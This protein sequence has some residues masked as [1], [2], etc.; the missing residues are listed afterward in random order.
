MADEYTDVTNKEQF[1]FCIRA[2]DNTLE[3]KED[4]LGFYEL[5]NIKRVTVVNVI[6]D[7]FLRFNLNLQ[8]CG[9]QTYDG[10]S[11]MM[12]KKSGVATKLLVEQVK[13]LVTHYQ[14][15]SDSL[16]VKDL[17]GCYKILCD[18]MRTVREIFVLVKY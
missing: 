5:E 4:F 17:T 2:V 12:G 10:A 7:I 9:G 13:A 8:H 11:N 18:T 16:A 15:H 14:G 6:K 1:S 3:V